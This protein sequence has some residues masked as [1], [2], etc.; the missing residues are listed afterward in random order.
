MKNNPIFTKILIIFARGTQTICH[1][2]FQNHFLFYSQEIS[3]TKSAQL[4]EKGI[5]RKID[6][7]R[8]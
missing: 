1:L 4:E 6:S 7:H 3:Q 8:I 2:N 5:V